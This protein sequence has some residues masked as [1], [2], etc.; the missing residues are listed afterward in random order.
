MVM[1]WALALTISILIYM[2]L[3]AIDLGVGLPFG[4]TNG[5]ARRGAQC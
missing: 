4:L 5:E 3:G 2:R 1:F